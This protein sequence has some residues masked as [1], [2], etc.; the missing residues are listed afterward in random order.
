VIS[1]PQNGEVAR[2][3]SLEDRDRTPPVKKI[4]S[5]YH[6]TASAFLAP[7]QI[8]F[9][10]A[11]WSVAWAGG[12]ETCRWAHSSKSIRRD[13]RARGPGRRRKAANRGGLKEPP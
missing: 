8:T 9:V 2:N 3:W 7:H 12:V 5:A 10:S 1:V 4:S 11:G 6:N 13:R